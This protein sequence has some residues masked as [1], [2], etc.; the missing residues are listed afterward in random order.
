MPDLDESWPMPES[1]CPVCKHKFNRVSDLKE[2]KR[3]KPG[4]ITLCIKCAA[5]LHFDKEMRVQKLP[6]M[7][8]LDEAHQNQIQKLRAAILTAKNQP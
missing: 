8:L 1:S 2:S 5:V 7:D 3:P 4:D 6:C